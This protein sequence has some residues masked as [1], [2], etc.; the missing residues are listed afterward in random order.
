MLAMVR[1]ENFETNEKKKLFLYYS[2]CSI[3]PAGGGGF[4]GLVGLFATT[5]DFMYF[6]EERK[7][8]TIYKSIQLY[9]PILIFHS[10]FSKKKK[11]NQIKFNIHTIIWLS[12]PS[13][14]YAYL[15]EML[16]NVLRF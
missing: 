10:H 16:Y 2:V 13:C 1:L 9:C 8:K 12:F 3:I 15:K 14:T 7:G 5:R 4:C 6:E 11:K